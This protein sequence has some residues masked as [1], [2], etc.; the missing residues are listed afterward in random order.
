[1]GPFPMGLSLKTSS[2]GKNEP[3]TSGKSLLFFGNDSLEKAHPW[4]RRSRRDL[5]LELSVVGICAGR[6]SGGE[7][8]ARDLGKL[9]NNEWIRSSRI[10]VLPPDPGADGIWVGF[11]TPADPGA[12]APSWNEEFIWQIPKK[13]CFGS[14]VILGIAAGIAWR[15]PRAFVAFPVF[16]S[17][18]SAALGNGFF[19]GFSFIQWQVQPKSFPCLGMI[20]WKIQ[21]SCRWRGKCGMGNSIPASSSNPWNPLGSSFL[22]GKLCFPMDFPLCPP[23][24]AQPVLL[25]SRGNFPRQIPAQ[26]APWECLNPRFSPDD[27]QLLISFCFSCGMSGCFPMGIG[28]GRAHPLISSWIWIFQES[29]YGK[30]KLG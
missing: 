13:S 4:W 28:S 11:P 25:E 23:F 24:P 15:D 30:G 12:A 29:P 9:L 10:P 7:T 2:T 16:R 8:G 22:G 20:S 5:G 26:S 14:D 19:H 3:G 27:S 18:C 21:G 6:G 1:M 17:R